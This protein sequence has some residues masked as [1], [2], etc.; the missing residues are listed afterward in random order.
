MLVFGN[1]SFALWQ[2]RRQSHCILSPTWLFLFLPAHS[3]ANIDNFE[4][5][6]GTIAGNSVDST[7]NGPRKPWNSRKEL[8]IFNE[9]VKEQHKQMGNAMHPHL[10]EL[11]PPPLRVSRQ[12]SNQWGLFFKLNYIKLNKIYF[13]L[14]IEFS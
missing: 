7:M 4:P 3:L 1:S 9:K 11:W 6:E 12:K 10:P 8:A 14:F 5:P 2:I 13:D